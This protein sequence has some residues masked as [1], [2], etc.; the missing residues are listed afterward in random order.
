MS[1]TNQPVTAPG[2]ALNDFETLIKA[3]EN[4]GLGIADTHQTL[5][6]ITKALEDHYDVMVK[7]IALAET[8][9]DQLVASVQQNAAA[10]LQQIS[11]H[12]NATVAAI[13][14]EKDA[15]IAAAQ[16]ATNAIAA[17]LKDLSGPV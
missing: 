10:L 1:D 13:N 9:A 2:G 8:H 4:F 15:K 12:V 11:D 16:S 3:A 5:I 6:N 17:M 14:N 7:E